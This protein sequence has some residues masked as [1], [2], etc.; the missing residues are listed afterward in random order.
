MTKDQL[1]KVYK[2]RR[3]ALSSAQ[4]QKMEDL[5]LIQFQQLDIEIPCSIMT[6]A[7]FE[8]MN[9]FDPQLIT[10]YCYFKNQNVYLY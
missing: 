5:I 3:S 2:E 6:Y 4:R 7:P 1:R 8:K 9:E 10:D